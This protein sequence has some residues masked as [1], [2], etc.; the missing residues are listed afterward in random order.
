MRETAESNDETLHDIIDSL[1]PHNVASLATSPGEYV[2]TPASMV[3]EEFPVYEPVLSQSW[4][5][6]GLLYEDDSPDKLNLAK[7]TKSLYLPEDGKPLKKGIKA[8]K[9][10]YKPLVAREMS[11]KLGSQT[12]VVSVDANIVVSSGKIVGTI[13]LTRNIT[14]ACSPGRVCSTSSGG[15]TQ[16]CWEHFIPLLLQVLL[17]RWRLHRSLSVCG[18]QPGSPG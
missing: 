8:P 5:H 11:E 17:G 18:L 12:S 10:G 3:L 6:Q 9:T 7:S 13:L 2:A 14:V 4:N 1:T 15:R 16:G